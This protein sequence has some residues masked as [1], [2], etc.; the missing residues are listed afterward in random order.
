MELT[1]V[2]N[3]EA[4]DTWRLKRGEE[5]NAGLI[6]QELL[7]GG[8]RYEAYLAY[9]ESRLCLV[10]AKLV[11]PGRAHDQSTL[12]AMAREFEMLR[13]LDHPVITR[14]FEIHPAGPHP[15]LTLEYLEGPRLSTLLRRYGPLP[16]DQL[17]PLAMQL[18]SGLQ[19]MHNCGLVHLDVKPKNVIMSGPPRLIDLSVATTFGSAALLEVPTGTTGYMSPE[20]QNPSGATIVGP[21]ADSWGLGATLFEAATGRLPASKVPAS[22]RRR[23]RRQPSLP[24]LWVEAVGRCLSADPGDR[25][26][27]GELMRQLEPLAAALPTRFPLSPPRPGIGRS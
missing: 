15:H 3:R 13:Q 23:A 8:K 6:V 11:R 16:M 19:Y 17:L 4:P 9:D 21:G 27:P 5:I 2:A 12:T 7:G 24:E 25:P 20:Q 22:D 10:V 26:S 18:C 1:L 14:G